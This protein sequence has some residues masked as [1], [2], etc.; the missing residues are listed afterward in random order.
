MLHGVRNVTQSTAMA[1]H[2]VRAEHNQIARLPTSC[3]RV[4]V[5]PTEPIHH[6]KA[7]LELRSDQRAMHSHSLT[8]SRNY[9][10]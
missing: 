6:A 1:K 9:R 4:S 7:L 8:K 3:E 10:F 5:E 2:A